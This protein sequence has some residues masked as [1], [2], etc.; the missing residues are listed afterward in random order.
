MKKLLSLFV[1]ACALFTGIAFA[2]DIVAV[3]TPVA[4]VA[5]TTPAVV[6]P[7][8]KAEDNT[9]VPADELNISI[10]PQATYHVYSD[11][12]ENSLGVGAEVA[13][14]DVLLDNLVLSSGIE[15]VNS[16]FPVTRTEAGVAVV[17]H[18]HNTDL[19]NTLTTVNDSASL[20]QVI[21][22]NGLGYSLGS[23]IEEKADIKGLDV[24]PFVSVDSY[25]INGDGVSADNTVGVSTGVKATYTINERVSAFGALKYSWADA[26]VTYG[27][28][29]E[30][31]D[32]DNFGLVGGVAV[33]F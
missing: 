2:E 21:W 7:A 5:I 13:V 18:G 17:K 26:D 32:L 30:N 31:V 3:T 19:V 20:E 9:L 8:Y 1:V 23:I 24:V 27:N 29:T 6:V 33:K 11:T 28:T 16:D 15:F 4:D 10:T 14:K 12:L 25:F 22:S